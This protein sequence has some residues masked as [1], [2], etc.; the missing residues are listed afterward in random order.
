MVFMVSLFSESP[1]SCHLEGGGVLLGI[2]ASG[3]VKIALKRGSPAHR[4]LC[5]YQNRYPW[6]QSWFPYHYSW[7]N[8]LQRLKKSD[9]GAFVRFQ[10]TL[11]RN[12]LT[13]HPRFLFMRFVGQRSLGRRLGPTL[14]N[15]HDRAWRGRPHDLDRPR[16][17]GPCGSGCWSPHR[18]TPQRRNNRDTWP[19]IHPH[20]S[21]PLTE[22][23]N[24]A[25]EKE[26]VHAH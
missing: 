18:P 13:N 10:F 24:P 16:K 17:L 19:L 21:H 25:V 26:K 4:R 2:R 23:L 22:R 5:Y 14:T 11:I 20:G 15:T 9:E 3:P 1:S 8:E 6:P 12:C 7:H